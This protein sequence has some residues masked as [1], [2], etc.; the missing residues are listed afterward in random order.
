VELGKRGR[1]AQ[2]VSFAQKQRSF[3]DDSYEQFNDG[4]VQCTQPN[5]GGPAD[6]PGGKDQSKTASTGRN[7]LADVRDPHR[8]VAD[9]GA[10]LDLT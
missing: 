1:A 7:V 2:D 10:S 4:L 6:P 9:Q 8:V 3:H 5:G